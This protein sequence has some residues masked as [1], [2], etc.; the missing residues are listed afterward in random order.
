MYI[1]DRV[2]TLEQEVCRL[3]HT[4]EDL[5]SSQESNKPVL[6]FFVEE[7]GIPYEDFTENVLRVSINGKKLT[8]LDEEYNLERD[9]LEYNSTFNW[10]DSLYWSLEHISTMLSS[11]KDRLYDI[12]RE[13]NECRCFEK[14]LAMVE[15]IKKLIEKDYVLIYANGLEFNPE[16]FYL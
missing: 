15:D 8:W 13:L 5:I 9:V 7:I 12:Y 4:I 1:E 6:R 3:K 10:V 2:R 14:S 11:D 16:E